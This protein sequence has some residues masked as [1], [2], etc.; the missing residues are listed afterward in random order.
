MKVFIS[1]SGERSKFVAEALNEWLQQVI[2]VVMPF[3][4]PDIQKGKKWQGEISGELADSN[5]GLICLT[6]ENLHS[7]WLLFEAGALSK[8]VKE[9][10]VA[11]LLI[12]LDSSQVHE[13]LSM[14]QDT[15]CE[16][17]DFYKLV[18][19]INSKVEN[20]RL[21]DS[22][23]KQAFEMWWPKLDDK[24]KTAI[25]LK[26]KDPIDLPER[27][28][29]DMILEILEISRGLDKDISNIKTDVVRH[30]LQTKDKSSRPSGSIE[31]LYSLPLGN[32]KHNLLAQLDYNRNV[33]FQNLVKSAAEEYIEGEKSEPADTNDKDDKKDRKKPRNK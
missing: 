19:S 20:N 25:K 7:D 13:P 32:V 2:Q 14:F 16:K 4:S 10:N 22:K 31:D 21:T 15:K 1:W 11:T 3:F 28:S 18:K 12:N 6:S 26:V 8:S 9:S 29:E 17:I 27:S 23:L 24:L 33:A 5:F 30:S